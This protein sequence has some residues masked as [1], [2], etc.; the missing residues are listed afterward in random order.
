MP[1]ELTKH[2][3]DA[4]RKKVFNNNTVRN[5]IAKE[6][7]QGDG[8]LGARVVDQTNKKNLLTRKPK[9]GTKEYLKYL[10]DMADEIKS[11]NNTDND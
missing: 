1:K 5:P 8:R 7:L 10:E 4:L 2:Q 6:L 11:N 9:Y 3:Y